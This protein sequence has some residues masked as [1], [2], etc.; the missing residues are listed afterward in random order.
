LFAIAAMALTISNCS[1]ENPV[2]AGNTGV[3]TV[4][5]I[6][7]SGEVAV[8][9]GSTT[10]YIWTIA[11]DA[12]G[13]VYYSYQYR[14]GG[15]SSPWKLLGQKASSS[16][17][18]TV[19][20]SYTNANCPGAWIIFRDP[21]G[22]WQAWNSKS[23]A[24]FSQSQ[25]G[26]TCPFTGKMAGAATAD[27]FYLFGVNS[28]ILYQ[29]KNFGSLWNTGVTGA[30]DCIAVGVST[31]NDNFKWAFGKFTSNI[32]YVIAVNTST[33]NQPIVQIRVTL[34][35]ISIPGDLAV[36][37]NG[38]GR[39]EVFGVANQTLYH[40]YQMATNSSSFALWASLGSA[41]TAGLAVGSN[42]DNRLEVFY[43]SLQTQWVHQWQMTTGGWSGPEV[44]CP[45]YPQTSF[46]QI[47]VGRTN[48]SPY[49]ELFVTALIY[50]H[51]NLVGGI[52][53]TAENSGWGNWFGFSLN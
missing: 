37:V 2:S 48:L 34:S 12:G 17:I 24:T 14:D 42:A 4:A 8:L 32:P 10:G 39:M 43:P 38:D 35:G 23:G 44:L 29:S 13:S 6:N 41:G 46:S 11:V 53:Q 18:V 50:N 22:K 47:A 52:Q 40:R 19:F 49:R 5:S 15:W 16:N 26:V 1:K 30:A 31:Y 20:Q 36:G 27:G 25:K 7:P 51:G 21:Q 28:Q 3:Q 45:A 9:G 33:R